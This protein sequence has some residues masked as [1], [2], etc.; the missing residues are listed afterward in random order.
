MFN[1]LTYAPL[2][3][4]AQW[5]GNPLGEPGEWTDATGRRWVTQCDTAVTGR[6]GCRTWVSADVIAAVPGANG[7]V[8]FQQRNQLVFNNMVRFR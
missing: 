8:D 1:N 3:S 5:A 6:N 4:R 2:M 7:S